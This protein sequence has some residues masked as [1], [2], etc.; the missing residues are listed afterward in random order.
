MSAGTGRLLVLGGGESGA[1]AAVLGARQGWQVFLSDQ[2]RLRDDYRDLLL[3]YGIGFEEEGHRPES[4]APADIVVKSPGIPDDHAV[5]AAYRQQGIP[6]ISE[7]EWAY[8][9]CRGRILAVTGSNGKTTTTRLCHHLLTTGG[10]KAVLGGNIGRSF[11][12]LVLEEP[13]AEVFVLEI[14]SFQLDGI[15]AFRPQLSIL[16]NITP[17]H[18]DRYNYDL[19]LYAASKFR[20]QENQTAADCFVY[21]AEDPGIA[22]RIDSLQVKARRMPVHVGGFAGSGFADSAGHSYDLAGTCLTGRH[23]KLNAACA[24]EAALYYGVSPDQVQQGLISFV[25]DPHRLEKVA[26]IGGILYINDSKATNVD[27]VYYALEAMERPVIWIVGGQDKGNDYSVLDKLVQDRVKAIVCLGADNSKLL[28]HF[29]TITPVISEARSAEEAVQQAAGSAIS[30]DIVLL[31]PACASFD[32]FRN[33]MHRG[34]A[35][36]EAVET[37]KGGSEDS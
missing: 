8:K 35:F 37:L 5:V 17:D 22:T 29:G 6:V 21:N 16:L 15:A 10:V 31:S 26:E 14:S 4:W 32:L 7:I 12:N 1:W 36:K 11:A 24:T 23:N 33:Y 3:Q 20:I 27:A 2:G 9:F 13:D 28:A 25:N 19:G 34:D 30:G 18:L